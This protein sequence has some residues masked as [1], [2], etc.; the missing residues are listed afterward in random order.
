MQIKSNTSAVVL[1][2]SDTPNTIPPLLLVML[3]KNQLS[4]TDNPDRFSTIGRL[5]TLKRFLDRDMGNHCGHR[6][7]SHSII[8]G[9]DKGRL[10]GL[11]FRTGCQPHKFAHGNRFVRALTA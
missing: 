10:D 1:Y 11:Q 5:E 7:E 4:R 6:I 9:N 8:A 2:G 3:D